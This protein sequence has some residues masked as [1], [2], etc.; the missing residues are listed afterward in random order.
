[1]IKLKDILQELKSEGSLPIT[2][3]AIRR[4]K[5]VT[6]NDDEPEDVKDFWG[7]HHIH[8]GI[9]AGMA[10]PDTYDTDDDTESDPGIQYDDPDEEESG[11]EPVN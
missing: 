8:P 3:A 2:V 7:H 6:I 4:V 1:M 9:A 11:Y 10:E 5:N